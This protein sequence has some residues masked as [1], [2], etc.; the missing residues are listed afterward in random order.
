MSLLF[1]LDFIVD[2]QD[3]GASEPDAVRMAI[4]AF[5]EDWSERCG[6]ISELIEVFGRL[7]DDGKDTR[8][9]EMH[10]L[11]QSSGWQEV[12]RIR[13][14]LERLPELARVIDALGRCR[15]ADETDTRNPN[16]V[17]ALD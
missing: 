5:V 10:G 17:D 2:Y 8:W 13:R 12:L 9:D 16:T 4:E 11:L 3:R 15:P 6:E 14:L 1:H 7:P